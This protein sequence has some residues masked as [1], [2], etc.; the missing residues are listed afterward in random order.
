[1]KFLRKSFWALLLL[2]LL[3]VGEE[4]KSSNI[5]FPDFEKVKTEPKGSVFNEKNSGNF[6]ISKGF[7]VS[8]WCNQGITFY[9]LGISENKCELS[10]FEKEECLNGFDLGKLGFPCHCKKTSEEPL[11]RHKSKVKGAYF[12]ECSYCYFGTKP[13]GAVDESDKDLIK[14]FSSVSDDKVSYTEDI[15]LW[16]S[17][18]IVTFNNSIS[19]STLTEITEKELTVN[20]PRRLKSFENIYFFPYDRFLVRVFE[21][22]DIYEKLNKSWY[23]SWCIPYVESLVFE[24]NDL[25]LKGKGAIGFLKEQASNKK[26]HLVVGFGAFVFVATYCWFYPGAPEALFTYLQG[27][28]QLLQEFLA[29]DEIQLLIQ[30]IK[31]SLEKAPTDSTRMVLMY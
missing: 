19:V 12:Y 8:V 11:K 24:T 26:V 17:L 23:T 3:P 30:T 10:Y 15:T 4:L 28:T 5:T 1:M 7:T 6:Q 29:S 31:T 14:S 2:V 21:E 18:D 20:S 22:S 16:S 25:M 27:N 13:N 9:G